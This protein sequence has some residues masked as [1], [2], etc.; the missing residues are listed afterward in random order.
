MQET[1]S[2]PGRFQSLSAGQ[3]LVI[4]VL[5]TA[6]ILLIIGAF[7]ENRSPNQLNVGLQSQ[8][9][10]VLALL[11]FGAGLLSFLS[12]CTLP[13]L[14][15]YFAFAF[16]SGRA[17]IAANTLAFLTGLATTFTLFGAAG[18]ALGRVLGDNQTILMIVGGSVIMVMGVLSLL[19]QGFAGLDTGSAGPREATLTGSYVFGLTFAIGWTSCIG[20]IL[21]TVVTLAYYTETVWR[22]MSLLF[23]YTLGLG[24]PL[25]IVSTL[26]GRL[27]RHSR[28]W[29]LLR[30][31]GW[32][33]DTH[34]FV[35]ALLWALAIWRIM[36]AVVSYLFRTYPLFAGQPFTLGHEIGLLALAVAGAA[37]WTFTSPGSRRTT[38]HLHSTQLISGALFVMIAW[39][40][41]SGS[42]TAVNGL[43]VNSPIAEWLV[44]FEAN[45]ADFFIR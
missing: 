40:M 24:V 12:P 35:V 27:S 29:Q 28:F 4:A 25:L 3:K 18:F 39:L 19:G 8:P 1:T 23:I 11:A 43:L 2:L 41:L 14:T 15:A 26:F 36:A 38:V 34:M 30:G 20:P 9:Y 21:G 32:Q 42:L 10:F 17:Q 6:V 16:Q 37:L 5:A 22:G 44:N 31:K 13:V 33:W 45:I 7:N